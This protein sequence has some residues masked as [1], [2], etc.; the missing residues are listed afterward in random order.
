MET[1]PERA[2]DWPSLPVAEWKDTYETLHMWTQVVGKFRLKLCPYV[3]HWWEVALYA[4][5]RGLT[6]SPI[7]FGARHF[8]IAF[9][10][11]DHVLVVDA[12]DGRR[13]T[14]PLGPRTVASFYQELMALLASLGIEVKI[15]VE[16]KEIPNPIPF[17]QDNVHAAYDRW[18][19]RRW[20]RLMSQADRLLKQFRSD[21]LGKCSP[22]HFFWGSFDHCVTRFSGRRAPPRPGA[23]HITQLAYSHEVSSVGF[24]PGSGNVTEPAFYAYAAPAPDGYATAAVRPKEAFYN[25]PTQGFIL[26]CEAVR[27]AADPDRAVLEFFQSTYE[28]A[29]D[30]A[31]WD[32]AA[33]E[34]PARSA[35]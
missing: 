21:F 16:P 29:A 1:T 34:R 17:D 30:L 32:R 6:T 4:T 14:M 24:W 27:R 5:P 13:R 3:N 19:V 23:D 35:A 11:I 20:F 12:D 22:V 18:A 2:L 25:P 15:D 7:P 33:L 31:R 8:E 26:T 28:A 10:F 9:D